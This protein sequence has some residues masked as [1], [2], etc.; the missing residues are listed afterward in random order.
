[1]HIRSANIIQCGVS[2]QDSILRLG[3]FHSPLHLRPRR[4]HIEPALYVRKLFQFHLVYLMAP[5]PWISSNVGD[6]VFAG[7]V[8]LMADLLVYEFVEPARLSVK[9]LGGVRDLFCHAEKTVRLSE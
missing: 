2:T 1:M 7:K 3:N 4:D 5:H 9:A 6:G 8:F